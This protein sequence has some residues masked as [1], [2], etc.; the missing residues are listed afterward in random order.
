MKINELKTKIEAFLGEQNL[1]VFE[2]EG[3]KLFELP[4]TLSRKFIQ[5]FANPIRSIVYSDEEALNNED[6][7]IIQK[8]LIQAQ[9]IK[10]RYEKAEIALKKTAEKIK[11]NGQDLLTSEE[12]EEGFKL[13]LNDQTAPQDLILDAE[14]IYQALIQTYCT[15][16]SISSGIFKP[17]IEVEVDALQNSH[18][19]VA[20]HARKTAFDQMCL[21]VFGHHPEQ[22]DVLRKVEEIDANHKANQLMEYKVKKN[23]IVFAYLDMQPLSLPKFPRFAALLSSHD[24]VGCPVEEVIHQHK[25]LNIQCLI[26]GEEIV[27]KVPVWYGLIITKMEAGV[28]KPL[29]LHEIL[30]ESAQLAKTNPELANIVTKLKEDQPLASSFL[31]TFEQLAT[32]T[33][34]SYNQIVN[35]LKK[36]AGGDHASR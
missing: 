25:T 3:L 26:A 13:I 10:S 24:G 29:D 4:N 17:G 22:Y 36:K 1:E 27:V 30:N 31:H 9:I 7:K 12:V 20:Q 16:A 8:I 33:N 14:V 6:F 18:P 5:E 34:S 19:R 32:S 15:N 21:L 2:S 35:L 23:Q 28:T 11:N